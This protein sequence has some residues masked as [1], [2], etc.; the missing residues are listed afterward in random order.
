MKHGA[1]EHA[2][3]HADLDQVA[4]QIGHDVEGISDGTEQHQERRDDEEHGTG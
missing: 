2:R 1:A 3:P 4:V